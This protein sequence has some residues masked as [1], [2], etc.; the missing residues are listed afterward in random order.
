MRF[1]VHQ[2]FSLIQILLVRSDRKKISKSN[3]ILGRVVNRFSK[4]VSSI[5]EQL[6]DVT[7]NFVDVGQSNYLTFSMILRL[8]IGIF[9]YSINCYIYCLYATSI[10]YSHGIGCIGHGTSTS[11]LYTGCSRCQTT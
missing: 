3:S 1:F 8:F 7:Y 5:D 9:W 6:S 11:N 4:D 10:T 2:Y